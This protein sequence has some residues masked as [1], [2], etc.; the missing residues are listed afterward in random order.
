MDSDMSTFR[1]VISKWTHTHIKRLFEFVG[2]G[3]HLTFPA[4]GWTNCENH[5]P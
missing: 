5:H 3:G 2:N 1:S 4:D